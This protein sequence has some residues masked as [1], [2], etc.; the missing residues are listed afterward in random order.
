MITGGIITYGET[1][2]IA[3][4]ENKKAEVA[5]SF[6]FPDGIHQ[7]TEVVER[8]AEVRALAQ[9]T[10]RDLLTKGVQTLPKEIEESKPTT[11][12]HNKRA[13]AMPVQL[14]PEGFDMTPGA[15]NKVDNLRNIIIPVDPAAM[16]EEPAEKIITVE[17]II[18]LGGPKVITDAEL[19]DATTKHQTQVKNP[20]AI[21]KLINDLGVKAPPG[22]LIDMP[23]DKRQDYLDKLAL[24]KPLA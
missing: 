6:N 20:V 14:V 2:K 22:R 10:C 4:F 18:D 12:P 19:M 8:I 16:P 15:V 3:D 1:R 5:L 24:I 23:Q 9:L 17:K 7:S 13:P 21:K 11:K